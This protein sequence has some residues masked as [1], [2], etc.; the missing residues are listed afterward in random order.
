MCNHLYV[1]ILS[2]PKAF[3]WNHTQRSLLFYKNFLNVMFLY[4]ASPCKEY[5]FLAKQV[6]QWA[7]PCPPVLYNHYIGDFGVH[8]QW[9]FKTLYIKLNATI[10]LERKTS[11]QTDISLS[12]AKR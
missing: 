8:F 9:F 4:Y 3:S 12:M 11:T 5:Q 7:I 10:V 1:R 2:V 6:P